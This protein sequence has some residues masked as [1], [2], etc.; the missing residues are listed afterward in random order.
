MLLPNE[1]LHLVLLCCCLCVLGTISETETP[2]WEQELKGDQSTLGPVSDDESYCSFGTGGLE[3][4]CVILHHDNASPAVHK[5][6]E[7]LEKNG[8][9]QQAVLKR[10]KG[11][12]SVFSSAKDFLWRV[13]K[14]AFNHVYNVTVDSLQQFAEMVRVVF[15]EETYNMISAVGEYVVNALTTRGKKCARTMYTFFCVKTGM[16]YEL[17]LSSIS[18]H[19]LGIAISELSRTTMSITVL[20]LCVLINYVFLN[21]F[22]ALSLLRFDVIVLLIH[23][24]FGPHFI[25]LNFLN[26]CEVVYRFCWWMLVE[27]TNLFLG[28][29]VFLFVVSLFWPCISWTLW[30]S[31]DVVVIDIE[32]RLKRM[33]DKLILMESRQEEILQILT[34]LKR[35][36]ILNNS[37][38]HHEE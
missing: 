37:Q 24:I 6:D 15:N 28:I 18:D 30:R 7:N 14:A 16:F 38:A 2:A 26:L 20:L 35:D 31:T 25:L 34:Q 8:E 23:T 22:S 12:L 3:Q 36:G 17:F 13:P 4:P 11:I 19:L 21:R 29:M 33:Q 5:R 32:S 10:S 27:H 9:R 1:V